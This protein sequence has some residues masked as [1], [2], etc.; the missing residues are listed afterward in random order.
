M[1]HRSRGFLGWCL[2]KFLFYIINYSVKQVFRGDRSPKD[3]VGVGLLPT[4]FAFYPSFCE[5]SN[6]N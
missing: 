5:V 2:S 1:N 3:P 6:G 4:S